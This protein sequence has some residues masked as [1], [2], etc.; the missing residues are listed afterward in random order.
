MVEKVKVTAEMFLTSL[1]NMHEQCR[2]CR[3]FTHENDGECSKHS[4][5]RKGKDNKCEDWRYFA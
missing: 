3:F 1:E 2:S 4:I 5:K